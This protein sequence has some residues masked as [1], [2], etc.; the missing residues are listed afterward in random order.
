MWS[1]TIDNENCGLF[2]YHQQY[3]VSTSLIGNRSLDKTQ[4]PIPIV[5][6]SLALLDRGELQ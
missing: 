2:N 5:H 4:L 6:S 1:I 3:Q